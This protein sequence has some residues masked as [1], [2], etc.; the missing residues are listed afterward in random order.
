MRKSQSL[1]GVWEYTPLAHVT[2]VKDGSWHRTTEQLPSPGHMQLPGHWEK[3]GLSDFFGT[4]R[5]ERSFAGPAL[6]A[7]ESLWFVC[8]GA[9]YFTTLFINDHPVGTHEGYFQRWE[10]DITSYVQPGENRIALEVT[11]PLEDPDGVWPGNKRVIKGILTHWDCRPGSWD[12]T[13]GQQQ[14]SGGV[15]NTVRLEVRPAVFIQHVRVQTWLTLANS[16]LSQ[17]LFSSNAIQDTRSV[18]RVLLTAELAS[19]SPDKN[20]EPLWLEVDLAGQTV[21]TKVEPG[22]RSVEIAMT[23]EQPQLWWTWDHGTPHLYTCTVRLLQQA[24]PLDEKS[25]QVGIREI[26]IDPESGVWTLNGKRIFIRGTNIVPTLWLGEYGQPEIEQDITLLKQAHVNAVRVCVHVNREE[27]YSALDQAG[28]L[29]WQDFA[30]QW[31][32]QQD[33]AFIAEAVRQIKTMVRQFRHHPSIAIWCCQNESTQFNREVLDPLLAYAAREEDSSRYVRPTSEFSEH[34]YYGWYSGSPDDYHRLPTSS[35]ITEFGAQALPSLEETQ[36]ISGGTWPPDWKKLAYH[37]FQPDQTFNVAHV[38]TGTNWADFVRNSQEYQAAV[39]KVAIEHFRKAR[40]AP[41]GCLFQFMFMD[42]WPSITWSI[43]SAKRVPKQ[44]YHTLQQVYQPV[45]VGADIDRQTWGIS[46]GKEYMPADVFITPWIVND[47]STAY[48]GDITITLIN[49]TSG[50]ET[51]VSTIPAQVE[52]DSIFSRSYV[53]LNVPATL[54]AG[55][56]IVQ[57]SFTQEQTLISRNDYT[58]KITHEPFSAVP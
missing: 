57:L 12:P 21:R 22:S 33:D 28:I 35:I 53:R 36:E 30:L 4:V 23:V 39:L 52:A 55:T 46:Q 32:Y 7:G 1:N 37:D 42:C 15:W 3:Q 24:Q 10:F 44:G 16:S 54:P 9:D 38:Q 56:Y 18:A 13:T 34:I 8:D 41:V 51:V 6:S 48:S 11:S 58:V 49:Q 50:E 29:V 20:T 25:Q 40:F 45:L 14:H 43:I 2:I 17:D 31:G 47:R 26:Q 19:G 5:F 27:L